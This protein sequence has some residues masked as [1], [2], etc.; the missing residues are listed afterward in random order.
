[1][2]NYRESY[3]WGPTVSL[4]VCPQQADILVPCLVVYYS[5]AACSLTGLDSSVCEGMSLGLSCV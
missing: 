4:V 3:F 1:M 5:L 2:D